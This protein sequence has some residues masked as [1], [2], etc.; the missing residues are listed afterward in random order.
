MSTP[1]STYNGP[2]AI[3]NLTLTGL[4]NGVKIYHALL[5]QTGSNP[6]TAVVLEN[7]LGGGV[8]PTYQYIGAGIY[9]LTAVPLTNPF[10]QGKTAIIFTAVTDSTWA[11]DGPPPL[12]WAQWN[13]ADVIRLE[14][15]S[16]NVLTAEDEWLRSTPIKIVVY[17]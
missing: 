1:I 10:P 15:W 2:A 4:I 16:M 17:P 12:F 11:A 7:S 13:N 8:V 14:T 9:T 6:P 3:S 5:T